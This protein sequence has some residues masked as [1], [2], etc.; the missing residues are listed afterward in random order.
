[1]IALVLL[2]CAASSFTNAQEYY[3]SNSKK[4]YLTRSNN[5]V[6]IL[7]PGFDSGQLSNA[8]QSS[9][10][11]VKN[12]DA[13]RG[14]FLLS[15]LDRQQR[16]LN[17][18]R[19]F[20]NVQIKKTMGAYYFGDSSGDTPDLYLTDEFRVK[21]KVEVTEEQIR[22][23]NKLHDV[24]IVDRKTIVL[25]KSS[26]ETKRG[27]YI[28]RTSNSSSLSALELAN[29]YY[30]NE[31]VSKDQEIDVVILGVDFDNR[32][33]T[34]GHKQVLEN[35]W[36]KYARE[37]TPGTAV[38]GEVVKVTDRGAFVKLSL[39]AEA[40]L[41]LTKAVDPEFKEG[42]KVEAYIFKFDE[43]GKSIDLSQLDSDQKKAKT[44]KKEADEKANMETGAPTLGEMSGLGALKEKMEAEERAEAEKKAAKARKADK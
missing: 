8:I 10:I 15:D 28:L 24:Q 27:R 29:L 22:K 42:Q 19:L 9:N 37:Y 20:D 11:Q 38:E 40:F 35:P 34:L 7:A 6:V 33:I 25:N 2:I 43:A 12:L 32:R 21:F 1:M 36:E 30:E 16:V 39:G 4:N 13:N 17:P 18:N 14:F 41:N 44:A 31:V 23:L 26:G 3:Y 5:D